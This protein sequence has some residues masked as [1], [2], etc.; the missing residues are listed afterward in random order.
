MGGIREGYGRDENNPSRAEPPL[1]KGISSDDGRD[2]AI[3]AL[4][5][6]QNRRESL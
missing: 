5:S 1:Y 4:S 2:G 3:I 6:F